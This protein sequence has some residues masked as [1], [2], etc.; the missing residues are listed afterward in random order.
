MDMIYNVSPHKPFKYVL[1]PQGHFAPELTSVGIVNLKYSIDHQHEEPNLKYGRY[2]QGSSFAYRW[3]FA[4]ASLS[5]VRWMNFLICSV[6]LF[7][8]VGKLNEFLEKPSVYLILLGLIFVNYYMI[9]MSFQFTPVFLIAMIGGIA[10]MK[11]VKYQQSVGVLFLILGALT[12]YF[13]L[14]TTPILT[15]GIPLLI[16]LALQSD[17][18]QWMEKVKLIIFFSIIWFIGYVATWAFKWLLIYLFTDYSIVQEIQ[19]QI[20]LRSGVWKG[21]RFDA[22]LA[23][24]KM[25]NSVPLFALFAGLILL[26]IAFFNKKGIQKATLFLV[27]SLIPLLWMFVTANH[28]EIHSWFTYRSLWIT[29]SALFLSIGCMI[30]WDKVRLPLIKKKQR[31]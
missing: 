4:I 3:L 19:Q 13:D 17:V 12:C 27:I 23:N 9:F 20:N 21:S 11:R 28:V 25:L 14:L 15:L 10:M 18:S 16:W 6:V 2:W 29:L 5:G 22:I 7:A 1:F 8:F 24:V 26:M 30:S 31:L